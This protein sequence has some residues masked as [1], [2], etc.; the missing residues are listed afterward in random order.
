MLSK[1]GLL[2]GAWFVQIQKRNVTRLPFTDREPRRES[3]GAARRRFDRFGNRDRIAI[4]PARH[5][6]Q[7]YEPAR[8]DA[9]R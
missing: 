2:T 9:R 4:G 7:L 1:A 8:R 3:V 5:E 6:E